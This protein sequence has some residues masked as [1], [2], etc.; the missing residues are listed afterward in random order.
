M[1]Q[2]PLAGP[3]NQSF[4]FNWDAQ[5]SMNIYP[6]QSATG[7]SKTN[8]ALQ[9]RPGLRTFVTFDLF[10]QRGGITANDRNFVVSGNTLYEIFVDNTFVSRGTLNSQSGMVGLAFNGFQVCIVDGPDGYIFTLATNTLTEITDPYFL[11]SNTV[12][13]DSGYFLFVKPSS[14]LY[15]ISALYDGLTGDPLDFAAAEGSPDNLLAVL[16]VHQQVFLVGATTTQIV[17]NTGGADFPYSTVPGALIQYGT[18]AAFSV[19]Q[20]ANML[21]FLGQ[22]NDGQAAVWQIEGYSPKKVSTPAVEIKLQS[23]TDLQNCVAYSYQDQGRYFIVFN[24]PGQI[25]WTFEVQSGLWHERAFFSDGEYS[26]H[27]PLFHIFAYGK[28]L[29][30]DY[31]DGR[32]YEQSSN[33]FT[34]DGAYIRTSRALPPQAQNDLKYQFCSQAQ[35]D[36]ET[37]V[38]LDGGGGYGSNGAFDSGFDFGFDIGTPS[39]VNPANDLN[40]AT[41]PKLWL[42]FSDDGGHTW[43]REKYASSGKV[44]EYGIRVMWRR[45]GRFRQRVWE[46]NTCAPCKVFWIGFHVQTEPGYA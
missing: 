15:Y 10:P 11:G 46:I 24:F 6:I 13:F 21:F 31:E 19:V 14:Q 38:G 33:F 7:T 29:M 20:S 23:Y 34:D 36:M 40:P 41:N 42:R 1:P 4:S 45:L 32:L 25:S 26:R 12:A 8:W 27:R 28:H 18:V 44:G 5:R 43:S 30:G 35:L 16:S 22:D 9:G 37:G 2:I 39:D 17:T 3:S